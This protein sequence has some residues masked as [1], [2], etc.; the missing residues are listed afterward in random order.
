MKKK[1]SRRTNKKNLYHSIISPP[2]K[3]IRNG[4]LAK[5][6]KNHIFFFYDIPNYFQNLPEKVGVPVPT[7]W[8]PWYCASAPY[9]SFSNVS[10]VDPDNFQSDIRTK[11]SRVTLNLTSSKIRRNP[12]KF[13]VKL[14]SKLQP[15]NPRKIVYSN[16]DPIRALEFG[17]PC[18]KNWISV[19]LVSL[20]H[21]Y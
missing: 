7:S 12:F 15:A 4:K 9:W 8:N 14:D 6:K 17:Y 10:N 5:V 2:T 13:P 21:A 19:G 1:T 3:Q 11:H 18:A 16:S 20:P